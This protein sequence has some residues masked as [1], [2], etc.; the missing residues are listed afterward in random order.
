MKS[1][2]SIVSGKSAI[3]VTFI[4]NVAINVVIIINYHSFS[5]MF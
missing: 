1:G 3:A 4:V 2:R 5:N